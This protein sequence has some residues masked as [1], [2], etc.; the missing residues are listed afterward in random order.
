MGFLFA[1]IGAFFFSLVDVGR[2]II[3][4]K[5]YKWLVKKYGNYIDPSYSPDDTYGPLIVYDFTKV[6]SGVDSH[7]ILT[8][9]C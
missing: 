6:D 5:D 3:L 2:K 7:I 4:K 9:I 8:D 1:A